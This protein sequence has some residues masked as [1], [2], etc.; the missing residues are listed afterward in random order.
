M[1]ALGSVNDY[2]TPKNDIKMTKELWSIDMYE[3]V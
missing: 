1:A 3:Y 2:A